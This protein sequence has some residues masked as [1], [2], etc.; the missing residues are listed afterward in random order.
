MNTSNQRKKNQRKR[1]LSAVIA[2]VG[3][4]ALVACILS[5]ENISAM[6][7]ITKIIVIIGGC[8]VFGASFIIAV[9]LDKTAGLYECRKCHHCFQ[10]TAAAYL[11][12][13]RSPTKRYLKCPKCGKYCYCKVKLYGK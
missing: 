10:P 12:G 9:V 3:V 4:C 8:L 13:M 7:Q 11:L 2:V 1:I 5:A 6:T